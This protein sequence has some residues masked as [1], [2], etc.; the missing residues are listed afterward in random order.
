MQ[1]TVVDHPLAAVRLTTLRAE[2][3]DNAS[4]RAALKELTQMLVYEAMRDAAVVAEPVTTPLEVTDGARLAAPPLLV[5]VLRA[6][7]GMV[8]QAHAMLP[9]SQV[10]FVGMGRNEENYVPEPYF[11]SLPADLAGRPVFVLDPMLATGGSMVETL[12]LLAQRGATDVTA[13]CVVAAPEGVRALTDCGH[14]VRLV[15]ATV[16]RGLNQDAYIVPGLGDAGDRQFG[17]RW[18]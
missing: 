2:S 11:Q 4:F 3:T 17:P 1:I 9:E 5:P 14:P 12:G 7:L 6:G 16:D 8:D 18:S 15:T 10:G 13:V